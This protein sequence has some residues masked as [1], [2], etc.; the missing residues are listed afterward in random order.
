MSLFNSFKGVSAE[1][2]KS[3]IIKDLKGKDY[4]ENLVWN[5]FEGINVQP[6][7]HQDLMKDNIAQHYNFPK[8]NK[9]W[10]IRSIVE[11]DNCKNANQKALYALKCGV[12]SLLFIG[13]IKS[14][15]DL[16]ILLND[17]QTDIIDVNI[18]TPNPDI[19]IKNNLKNINSISFDFLGEVLKTGNWINSE[20]ED[21]LQ[22]AK[23]INKNDDLNSITING[24]NYSNAGATIVQELAFSFSQMV[25][26]FNQ[27]S[28]NGISYDKIAQNIQFN[29]GINSNFFFEIAKIKAAKIIFQLIVKEFDIENIIP[30]INAQ[31][32]EWN[33]SSLDPYV[34]LLRCTTEGMSAIL[35]GCDSLSITP[36]DKIFEETTNFSERIAINIQ[37]L[38]KEESFLDK[39]NNPTDGTYYINQLTDEIVQK[40]LDLFKTIE[41]KGGF[42]AVIKS[43]FI[44]NEIEKIV[45]AKNKALK[46]EKIILLGTNKHPNLKEKVTLKTKNSVPAK[47]TTIQ[48]I[49]I[50]RAAEIFEAERKKELTDA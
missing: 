37:H 21:F 6:F 26:Y 20:K 4:N 12:N 7:Y 22:L 36:F 34:N 44:Q 33:L 42:L 35:G 9:S 43:N 31:T 46:T 1:E 16:T 10:L 39:V 17:I 50:Y 30:T 14:K 32:S 38:L 3:E 23:I 40:S 11:V 2:W 29:F 48:P 13:D 5:S 47:K 15:E 25:E 18:Y 27:L 49:K 45:I 8:K 41:K 19:L 24:V 28:E